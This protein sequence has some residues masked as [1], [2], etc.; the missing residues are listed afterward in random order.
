MI[1]VTNYRFKPFMSK[2]ETKEVLDMFAEVG[3][4]P[5]TIAHYVA[6]DGHHGIVITETDDPA[7][8]YRNLLNY[9]QWIEFNTQVVLT[10]EEAVPLVID[11][12]S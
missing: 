12:V 1:I 11:S 10:V 9:T 5:G 3:N 8:G 4:A 7:E 6:T 2:K